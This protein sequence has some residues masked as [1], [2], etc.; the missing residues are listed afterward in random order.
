VQQPLRDAPDQKSGD[1]RMPACPDDDHVCAGLTRGIGDHVRRAGRRGGDHFQC[2]VES[3]RLGLCDLAEDLLLQLVVVG[4]ERIAARAAADEQLG[5]VHSDQLLALAVGE[6]LRERQRAVGGRRPIRRPQNRLEHDVLPFVCALSVGRRGPVRIG[7]GTESSTWFAA[8]PRT[9]GHMKAVSPSEARLRAVLEAGMAITSELSLDALLQRVVETAAALTNAR[10]AALG[11]IDRS[12]SQLERFLTTGIDP[13]LQA[14]IGDLPTGRGVLGVLIRDAVP[15]RLH[16]LGEDPRSVGFPPGHPPMQTFLGVPVLL[17]GI[18][19][20][21]LYLTEKA[22]GEDFT[23]E[24]QDIVTLLAAQAA[25]AIENARLYEATIH[26][27]NQLESLNEIG[28]ALATETDIDLLLDLVARRLRELLDARLVVVLLPAG[29]D[30][31]R[32]VAV[33]GEGTEDLVGQTMTRA[34][35]KSGRV[36]ERGRSERSDSVLD[37]PDVDRDVVRRFGA[38]TGLW[39]PLIARGRTIGLIAAHDKLGRDARFSDN[40]L[41]LAETFASRAAV[42]VDLSQ[43]I[44]RDALRRVVDAQ[45]LER[46]RLA[47][48]LHDETGQALT[49]ILLGLRALEDTLGGAGSREA[50]SDLRE[51]VVATLQDVRRLAVELRPK[52]LDDFGLVPALERLTETFGEQTGITVRFEAGIRDERLPPESETALYRIVQEAL[53]NIVKHAQARNVSIVLTRKAGSVAAVIEDDGQGFDP[54][55]VREDGFGIEGMRE[56]V[57]LLDGRLE[58]ESSAESGTTL[59]AEVPV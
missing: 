3:L 14:I 43:W 57:A 24:D 20:G 40:D 7:V 38:R 15:L 39:V 52:V 58:V 4:V 37:D 26:W 22:G 45:E 31:L 55:L 21:N 17:R 46:R 19:Y 10:Y 53:T 5:A 18:A 23:E 48:E 12:G 32:F 56:R 11:V 36:F 27:S 28:N 51:L 41:R 47:R 54:A 2:G 9:I 8:A 42:A 35:S 59:V 16:D 6:G 13:E 50:V 34:A 49:S 44:R 30:E 1:G 29:Q 33:A 25:V